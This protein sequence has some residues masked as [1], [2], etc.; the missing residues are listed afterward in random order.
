MRGGST[1]WWSGLALLIVVSCFDPEGGTGTGT[2]AVATETA[3]STTD[4]PT[5]GSLATTQATDVA[6]PPASIGSGR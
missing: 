1:R 5:S 2:D 6:R 4:G 3:T